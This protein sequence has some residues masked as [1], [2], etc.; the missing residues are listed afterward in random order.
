[1]SQEAGQRLVGLWY[2]WV[3][4]W[5]QSMSGKRVYVCWSSGKD[6]CFCLYQ[7]MKSDDVEVVGLLTTVS[8]EG[9]R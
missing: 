9:V 2:T 4:L 1:M 8:E 7:L 6:S 5:A 3:D